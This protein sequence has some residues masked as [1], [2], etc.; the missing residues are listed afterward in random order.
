MDRRVEEVQRAGG[1]ADGMQESARDQSSLVSLTF[2]LLSFYRTYISNLFINKM[3]H[4][5]KNSK[6]PQYD[7]SKK[8]FCA[9]HS[10]EFLTNFCVDSTPPSNL[11][12]CLMPLCPSCIV[13]H[14]EEHYR[15]HSKPLYMNIHEA[16]HDAR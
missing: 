8:I 13:E 6:A 15:E 16:L 2:F 7:E 4:Y 11:E 1:A 14:T 9:Y 3:S 5:S 12:S 10:S